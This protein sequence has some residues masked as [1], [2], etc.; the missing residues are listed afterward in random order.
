MA[1]RDV[2]NDSR[3]AARD[4]LVPVHRLNTVGG[5]PTDGDELS[6]ESTLGVH[7]IEDQQENWKT[8]LVL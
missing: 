5:A 7:G 6:T 1:I 8:E 4:E 2:S 3:F